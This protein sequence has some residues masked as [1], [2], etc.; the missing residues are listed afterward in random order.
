MM[1]NT[2]ILYHECSN[3]VKTGNSLTSSIHETS[4]T[5]KVWKPLSIC[6]RCRVYVTKD[7]SRHV[8]EGK[9]M[10][11]KC[12]SIAIPVDHAKTLTYITPVC[13][14]TLHDCILTGSGRM[15]K[16]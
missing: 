7:H 3:S 2:V 8:S 16:L 4:N 11:R 1:S 14:W 13:T 10:R 9:F 6:Y 5:V 12:A 15:L